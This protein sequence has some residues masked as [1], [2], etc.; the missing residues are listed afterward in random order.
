MPAPLETLIEAEAIQTHVELEAVQSET[1]SSEITAQQESATSIEVTLAK[2]QRLGKL[3]FWLNAALFLLAYETVSFGVIVS[4]VHWSNMRLMSALHTYGQQDTRQYDTN[5][6]YFRTLLVL[7][8]LMPL[9]SVLKIRTQR[10][11]NTLTQTVWKL[12]DIRAIGPLARTFILQHHKQQRK[13]RDL[14]LTALSRLMLLHGNETEVVG[15][16]AE[17]LII[18]NRK[19]RGEVIAALVQLLPRLRSVDAALLSPAQLK[20][21]NAYVGR[22]QHT[23]REND[24]EGSFILTLKLLFNQRKISLSPDEKE[25]ALAILAA[26][27]LIGDGTELPIVRLVARSYGNAGL[28]A[29]VR[30]A[31]KEYLELVASRK[32]EE[33]LPT[34]LLRASSVSA[35]SSTILLRAAHATSSA[36][37]EELLRATTKENELLETANEETQAMK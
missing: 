17:A 16:L 14:I 22:N 36:P 33:T 32:K 25:L 18:R 13:M 28:D 21:L 7:C 35:T 2:M 9:C 10:K 27:P 30:Q 24:V 15:P 20:A 1:L 29:E 19:L 8:V 31:A 6:V 4:F 5:P 12:D 26:Y 3:C 11:L 23:L 37:P 34:T